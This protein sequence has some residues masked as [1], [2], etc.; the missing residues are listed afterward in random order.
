M[1]NYFFALVIFALILPLPGL[2]IGL[3]GALVVL[4][5]AARGELIRP[6]RLNLA[7]LVFAGTYGLAFALGPKNSLALSSAGAFVAGILLFYF[8][9][10]HVGD[11]QSL[12][13]SFALLLAV[14]IALAA[15]SPFTIEQDLSK[16]FGWSVLASF[17]PRLPKTINSNVLSGVFVALAPLAG[18]AIFSSRSARTQVLGAIALPLLTLDL[19]LLQS[20][21]A[22][23]AVVITFGL[24]LVIWKRWFLPILLAAVAIFLAF[25][26]QLG[27]PALDAP[28]GP[29]SVQGRLE[30]RQEAWTLAL[31]LIRDHPLIGIG[32]GAFEH[33]SALNLKEMSPQT[34]EEPLPHAHNFFLQIALDTGLPGLVAFLALLFFTAR[35]LWRARQGLNLHPL[36]FGLVGAWIGILVH[37]LMD[38]TLWDTRAS[39][40][41]WWIWGMSLGGDWGNI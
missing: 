7:W 6:A 23:L 24:M 28:A 12:L 22:W 40:V 4:V 3:F 2:L 31:T 20:R 21:S 15:L 39:L 18:G 19:I 1:K 33:Y 5:F 26:P 16:S 34:Y 13:T 14:G 36:Y 8:V 11:T 41:L 29:F 10:T 35:S 9:V 25:A 37:G 27:L 30:R 38:A 17:A 32:A